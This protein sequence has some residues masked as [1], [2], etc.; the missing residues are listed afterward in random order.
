MEDKKCVTL[1]TDGACSGNPGAGG[2]GAILIYNGRERE[3]SGGEEST[4]N[5]R[6]ELMAVIMGLKALKYP[7]TVEV[8]SDSAYTVNAFANGWISSWKKNG[9]K[10]ADHKPVL[11]TDLWQELLSLSEKHEVTFKKVKGHA[12][13]EYNNRCDALA[14]GAIPKDSK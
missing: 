10:K 4:T 5:N 6:M 13:N 1:Y 11:N 8:Y 14:R 2:W 3:L 7:C 9:W 12:D